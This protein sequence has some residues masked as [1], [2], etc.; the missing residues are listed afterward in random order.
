MVVWQFPKWRGEEK[1]RICATKHWIDY[2]N[3]LHLETWYGLGYNNLRFEGFVRF[4][5]CSPIPKQ[6]KRKVVDLWNLH[7]DN[8]VQ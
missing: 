1:K 7:C 5:K 6:H 8:L 4:T 2:M 3:T